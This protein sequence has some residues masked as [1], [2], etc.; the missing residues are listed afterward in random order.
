MSFPLFSL[1]IFRVIPGWFRTG[2]GRT[3]QGAVDGALGEMD[4]K[5]ALVPKEL[6]H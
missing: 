6:T 5:T 3:G 4:V 1:S 2:R